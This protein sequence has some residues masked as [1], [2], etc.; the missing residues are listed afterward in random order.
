MDVQTMTF[1]TL[2]QT[3]TI[4]IPRIQRDYAQGRKNAQK[5]R[6]KFVRDLFEV[7]KSNKTLH[8]QIVYGSVK[9]GEFIP[10][11]GQ[12]RLTTLYLL[13]WYITMR[14]NTIESY[15]ANFTYE[16]RSSSKEFCKALSKHTITIENNN[17]VSAT[18][19]D[20]AWFL[21]FWEQDPTIQSMLTMLDS[22]HTEAI[23]SSLDTLILERFYNNLDKLIFSF[24]KLEDFG[25][26]D[27][28]YIKM[29]ARGAPLNDF[30]NFK[31]EFEDFVG[32]KF[33]D[34]KDK[35]NNP[36]AEVIA[37]KLDNEWLESVF[38]YAKEKEKDD[39]EC[40][41][42]AQS[43]M[44]NIIKYLC[45]MLYYKVNSGE[46]N[47]FK[48]D[49]VHFNFFDEKLESSKEK[50]KDSTQTQNIYSMD[51]IFET[52]E[53][54][55]IL[56]YVFDNFNKIKDKAANIFTNFTTT[57]G[58]S[59]DN[60]QVCIFDTEDKKETGLF[61]VMVQN[62]DL[63]K[64]DSIYLFALIYLMKKQDSNLINKL[65]EV[66]NYCN[67]MGQKYLSDGVLSYNSAIHNKMGEHIKECIEICNKDI[68]AKDELIKQ[69]ED[70]QY[71]KGD[72]ELLF[73]KRKASGKKPLDKDDKA[74]LENAK[75]ILNK[76][77]THSII[78]NLIYHG[79]S[80][81]FLL[82][83]AY[84]K[85]KFLVG[86]KEAWHI[87]LTRNWKNKISGELAT[88]FRAMFKEKLIRDDELIKRCKT[89]R[90]NPKKWQ[91]YFIKYN[92]S[93]FKNNHNSFIWNESLEIYRLTYIKRTPPLINPFLWTLKEKIKEKLKLKAEYKEVASIKAKDHC[94]KIP[95]KCKIQCKEA[96]FVLT[97][98]SDEY[99][100][101]LEQS[102][103][104][105][106]LLQFDKGNFTISLHN[107]D[108]IEALITILQA[109]FTK[110]NL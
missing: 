17:A 20:Q 3:Y 13:H 46:T 48:W 84:E 18:I 62:D 55:E 37:Q 7:L 110:E 53:A 2:V 67:Y 32:K 10:L 108:I 6:E 57:I 87:M 8:L 16:T 9:N 93:F 97:P 22:I 101:E 72:L 40:I 61:N 59:V 23:K 82:G 15:L 86:G 60:N 81:N 73:G 63:S 106:P 92:K 66:R 75:I 26:D 103:K 27:E 47:T 83:E 88:A 42:L 94:V 14:N 91:Y 30:E 99:K 70:H 104:Q 33:K 74:M 107:A 43:Y 79:F 19:K 95:N 29:N 90:I 68:V 65:R 45:E 39:M 5:I 4:K 89:K 36:M 11:D 12:Q 105:Q 51:K 50:S 34:V 31:A 41:E 21:P 56:I 77:Q 71:F 78:A 28:L 98:L 96:S 1:K 44:L 64:K 69:F 25:L 35:D 38:S 52:Q 80:G 49:I 76:E 24:I 85:S 58:D 54:L 102:Q 100:K 109:I